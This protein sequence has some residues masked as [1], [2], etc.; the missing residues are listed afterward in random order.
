MKLNFI[1]SQSTIYPEL[2]DSTSSKKYVYIR[3]NVVEKEIY[4][5]DTFETYT[6]Y[7]YDEAKLTKDEYEQYLAEMNATD[8]FDSMES[9]KSRVDDLELSVATTDAMSEAILKGVNEV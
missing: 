3:Q 1:K 5:N 8:I 2:I 7:E 6:Y 4:D 9:I